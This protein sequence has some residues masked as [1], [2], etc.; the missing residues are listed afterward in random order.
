MYKQFTHT[1]ICYHLYKVERLLSCSLYGTGPRIHITFGNLHVSEYYLVCFSA[2]FTYASNR[3][4]FPIFST[5]LIV[6]VS[7][8]SVPS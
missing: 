7:N 2:S 1:H 4:S 5:I 3:L 8:Q 6:C